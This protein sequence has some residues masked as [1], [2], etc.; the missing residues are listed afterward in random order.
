MRP[1]RAFVGEGLGAYLAQ[2]SHSV[3]LV[4]VDKQD[5]ISGLAHDSGGNWLILQ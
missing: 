3:D 2:E 1:T 4:V 5:A